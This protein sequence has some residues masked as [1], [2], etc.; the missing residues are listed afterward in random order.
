M[1]RITVI[2]LGF[3]IGSSIYFK[4]DIKSIMTFHKNDIKPI[5][6]FN[7]NGTPI[8]YHGNNNVPIGIEENDK[9]NTKGEI[10]IY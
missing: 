3:I 1:F 6:T 8:Y 9:S 5:M 2:G 10:H 7:K 4:N